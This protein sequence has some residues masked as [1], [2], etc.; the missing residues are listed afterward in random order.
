[1]GALPD[2]AGALN[3]AH[4]ELKAAGVNDRRIIALLR[5]LGAAG[6]T[7]AEI[8]SQFEQEYQTLLVV[9]T[10]RSCL[11]LSITDIIIVS[12]HSLCRP[13]VLGERRALQGLSNFKTSCLK[14]LLRQSE[15]LPRLCGIAIIPTKIGA[16]WSSKVLSVYFQAYLLRLLHS[17]SRASASVYRLNLET[18]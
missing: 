14:L 17:S 5:K 12:A 18:Y 11:D 1:M 9:S 10:G 16:V 3:I 4:E 6:H 15:N 7:S 8:A 13:V 2:I